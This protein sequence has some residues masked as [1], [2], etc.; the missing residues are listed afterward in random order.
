M[1]LFVLSHFECTLIGICSSRRAAE[2]QVVGVRILQFSHARQTSE[3]T[4]T[5]GIVTGGLLGSLLR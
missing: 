2:F 3:H 5:E 4:F 1:S